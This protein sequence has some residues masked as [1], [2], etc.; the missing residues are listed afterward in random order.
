MS[1][2][3]IKAKVVAEIDNMRDRLQ[4]MSETIHSYAETGYKEYA[5]S[6]LLMDELKRHNFEVTPCI[7]GIPTAFKAIYQGKKDGIKVS[8]LAEMDALPSL[9]HC[10]GHNIIGTAS[11]GAGIAASKVIS[12]TSGTVMV[13]GTPAE[14]AAV[15]LAGGKV[16]MLNEIKEADAAMLVHPSDQNLVRFK[17]V[18]REALKFEFRGKA[19]HAGSAPHLGVNALDAAVNTFNLVNALRQHL[20][21]DIRVHGIIV[22]GGSSPN[23]VPDYTEVKMYV[24]A[25]EKTSLEETVEKVKNCARGAALGT[26]VTVDISTYAMRYLNM[27][28]NPTLSELFQRNWESLSSH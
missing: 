22:N 25:I 13:F 21:S 12:E 27:V 18:C 16:R 9:G 14:E 4:V 20:K 28:C 1:T 24:R 15:D 7:A 19:A 6:K 23:I 3:S 11:I 17:N 5:T 2:K 10:C 26:G 8:F